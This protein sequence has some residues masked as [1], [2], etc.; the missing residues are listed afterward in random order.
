MSRK[1][2]V[3]PA[4]IKGHEGTQFWGSDKGKRLKGHRK[5]LKALVLKQRKVIFI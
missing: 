4:S 3:V 1:G 2:T 5:R